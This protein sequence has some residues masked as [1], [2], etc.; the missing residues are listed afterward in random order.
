MSLAYIGMSSRGEVAALVSFSIHVS[1]LYKHTKWPV[2]LK[3][4]PSLRSMQW[5]DFCCYQDERESFMES[6]ITGDETWV[7]EF[8]PKSK[9]NILIHPLQ[10]KIKN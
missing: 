9:R 5:S 1:K 7:Y 4:I 2:P 8:T 3:I 10:K 6:I